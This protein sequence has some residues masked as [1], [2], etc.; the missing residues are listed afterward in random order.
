[1]AAGRPSHYY[2]TLL[3][4]GKKEGVEGEEKKKKGVRSTFWFP[5][6]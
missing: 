4:I 6:I 2:S 5:S 1:M 3:A